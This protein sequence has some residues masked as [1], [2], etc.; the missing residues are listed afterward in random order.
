MKERVLSDRLMLAE[1][2]LLDAE[3]LLGSRWFKHLVSGFL[4]LLVGLA[5]F[6]IPLESV[7]C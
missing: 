4:I 6:T 2:G 1:R 3:G 7:T 5:S